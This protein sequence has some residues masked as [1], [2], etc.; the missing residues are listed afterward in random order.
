MGWYDGVPA[1][2]NRHPPVER[3]RRLVASMGG[4][5]ALHSA[6]RSAFEQGDYRWA[7]ELANNG[8]FA[9]PDDIV[10]RT[11]LADSY[12]QMG[13]QSESAIWRNIY[14]TGAR[15]LR[16]GKADSVENSG[17]NYLMAATPL[18]DF[19]SFLETTLV[20]EKAK[21]TRLA[22]NLV[23]TVSGERFAV[24]LANSVLVS[25]QGETVPGAP[26]LTA[27]KP[28]LLGVL[29]GQVPLDAMVAANQAQ[30]DGDSA[31]IKQLITFLEMPKLDFNIVEP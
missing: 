23:D 7:A 4:K 11:L 20:P 2:L 14:L 18:G 1:N 29:F 22:F 21:D 13:Y 28:V 19:L 5:S 25:E 6:A 12:E 15:E 10:S 3:A 9:D 27:P 30:V 8:V 17:P 16:Q 24:S 26:T 31:S